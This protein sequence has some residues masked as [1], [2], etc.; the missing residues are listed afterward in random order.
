MK[1]IQKILFPIDLA[2][3][4]E[5][6]LP[7]VSTFA[8]KFGAT[9]YVLY[10]TQDMSGFSTFY[11]PHAGIQGLQKEVMQAAEKEMQAAK[12]KFFG[13]FAKLETKVLS[14]KPA[15]KVLEFAKSQ[16]IDLIIM[17][18]HGR[19]GLEKAIFGSVAD[20]VVTGALCPVLTIHPDLA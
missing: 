10:V 14:G 20:R 15:D 7:W 3:K 18:A 11:V 13:G 6:F 9:V 4:Y 17:G 8:E 1:Q 5:V 16:K 12:Q 2:E 19:K